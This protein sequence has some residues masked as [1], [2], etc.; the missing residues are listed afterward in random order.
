MK[1]ANTMIA[2]LLCA[3]FNI[4]LCLT[5]GLLPNGN[6]EHGPKPSQMKGTKVI[7]PHS[8][9]SWEISGFV[10]YIKSGQKQGD[11]LLV[12][13]EGA[14]AVRLGDE[15]SIK[16]KVKVTN[17]MFYSIS[18]SAARTCAQ[19]ERLNVSIS[20]NNEPKDWGI[21]PIQTVYSSD[22]WDSYSWGFLAQ[23]NEIEIVIHNP[24]REKDL[25]CGPLI[26]SVALK[27]LPSPRRQ[28]GNML[29]NGN[30]EEGPYIFPNTSWGC[31]IPPNIEDDHSPLPGWIIESLKAVK[32]VDSD[33]FKVPEG[34]RAVELVAGRES[35]LAQIVRT[36]LGKTYDL[37]FSVGD[38]KNSCEGSMMVEAT[39]GKTILQVPYESKGNGGF[40]KA[41]LRFKAISRRTR[42][43]FLST[44]YHMKSDSTG[45]LCGPVIDDVRL[46]NVRNS[47]RA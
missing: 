46:V 38:A 20:P 27:T 44:F 31:L 3:T 15:A 14:S 37:K 8:I 42:I 35:A 23:S 1:T 40:K 5:D 13:P 10:E 4:A 12:V 47:R 21:L 7:D 30:F 41:K 34:K 43:R 22:G 28:R 19:E 26:D 17:G 24:G 33:H 6:F 36:E 32:Y 29:K 11:M 45:S 39:V 25:A 16:T 9:P 18:F 2:M